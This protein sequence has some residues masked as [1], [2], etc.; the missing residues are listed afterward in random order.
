VTDLQTLKSAGIQPVLWGLQ[1]EPDVNHEI[2]STCEYPDSASYVRTYGVVAAAVRKSFPDIGLFADTA[3]RFP[4]RIA[5][6]MSDARVAALVDFYAVHITGS[7]SETPG[8]V[9]A[10]IAAKLPA[11][12]WFQ[13]EYEY[14]TGAATPDRCLNTVQH[15]MNS[16]Q[17]AQNPTWFWLHV[18]KP[19]QNAEASGYSLGFWKSRLETNLPPSALT[20]RRWPAGPAF[21]ELPEALK[22]LEM[23]SVKAPAGGKPAIGYNFIVNQPVSVY[24]LADKRMA[25]KLPGDWQKTEMTATWEGGGDVVYRRQFAAG[26]IEIPAPGGAAVAHSVFIEPS[27]QLTLVPQIG[28]NLPLQ[29]RS[30]ALALEQMAAAVEPGHWIFNNYNWFA[31]GS[32]IRHV[33]WDS[34]V[35]TV[36]EQNY[37]A[38]ARVLAFRRPDG[39][40]TI[41]LSNRNVSEHGFHIATG[42]KDVTFRGYRYTPTEAG[43][44]CAGLELGRAAG[45]ILSRTLPGLSWEFWEEQ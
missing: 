26:K 2:Y 5:P 31:V 45:G 16:F 25:A 29:I 36:A 28:M 38:N 37:E 24:L 11:R 34:V 1:N 35:V 23:V 8:Q 43:Q 18:L 27:E 32:F 21:T 44:Q 14:L 10:K 20:F 19:V 15:I 22:K 41:A 12:P 9:A 42:L 17:L 3:D 30:Q 33:P 6:G 40:L 7:S 13:N 4:S 39:K